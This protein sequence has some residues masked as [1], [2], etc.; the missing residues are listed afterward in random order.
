VR[1]AED[2]IRSS[3]AV[4]ITFEL[5]PAA[6]REAITLAS[7]G[8]ARVFVQP[9]PPLA[10]PHLNALI[11]WDQVEVLLPNETEAR[12][13]L[14]SIS[15]DRPHHAD[16]LAAALA[17]ELA[18]PT[19]V[20]TL[21][22][23]GCIAHSAGASHRYSAHQA[24]SVDTTGASDAFAASLAAFMVAGTSEAEAIQAALAAAA[25]TIGRPGGHEAMPSSAQ[26]ISMLGRRR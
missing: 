25:W 19:V 2:S 3:D 5:P 10:D 23:S 1:A 17:T 7:G 12:A 9:A 20:V 24:A 18:V 4:L 21:G 8:G 13:I 22:E 6:I 16:D 15:S 26:V 14:E 11:P